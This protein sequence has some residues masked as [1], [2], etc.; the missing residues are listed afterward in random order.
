[1]LRIDR[2]KID[3]ITQIHF[4]VNIVHPA[5]IG[6]THV[7]QLID[8]E[9]I[10]PQFGAVHLSVENMT[11]FF[12]QQAFHADLSFVD[13]RTGNTYLLNQLFQ[14]HS[15]FLRPGDFPAF[16]ADFGREHSALNVLGF[17][18]TILTAPHHTN[19]IEY[20]IQLSFLCD[21]RLP[22]GRTCQ[23]IED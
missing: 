3:Q 11:V 7:F 5:I 10:S 9:I 12:I 1:M 13:F 16:L 6:L 2:C 8:E 14:F 15:G 4:P 20:R 17:T 23:R 19:Q 18:L 21:K 22:A